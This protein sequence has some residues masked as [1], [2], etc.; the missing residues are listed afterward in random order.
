MSE[1]DPPLEDTLRRLAPLAD[2]LTKHPRQ[3]IEPGAEAAEK[4]AMAVLARVSL[5]TG[6]GLSLAHTLG[7]GGM[8]VV[9]LGTQ[10][11][12]GRDVAVKSLKP[13]AR[14]ARATL[15]LLREAW[16]TGALEHP[17]VVP[18]Y[19][20][21]LDE[22][23]GPRL[24]LKRIEGVE[25]GALIADARAVAA[26]FAGRSLLEWNLSIFLQVAQAV[27]FAH[28]RG[29]VHRDLK[30]ENVMIGAF[31][32]VYVLD[33][34]IAVALAD[35]G[36]GRLPLASEAHEMAGTPAYMAPEMLG[37]PAPNL[38]VHTD[39]YLLGGLLYEI[40]C[41]R[42]PHAGESLMELVNAIARSRPSFP[43]LAPAE[44]VSICQRA[45]HRDPAKR[46]ASAEAL[47]L[48]VQ[49][50]L[51][52]RG[53]LQ[54]AREATQG[55]EELREELTRPPDAI[56][57]DRLYNA[58]GAVRFGF[59]QALR[60]WPENEHARTGLREATLRL[61]EHELRAGDPRSASTL[62]TE[63]QSPPA[64]LVAQ[65][66]EARRRHDAE[67]ARL[68]RAAEDF[69]PEVGRRTRSFIALVLGVFWSGMP[70]IQEIEGIPVTTRSWVL[71]SVFFLV[72]LIGAGIWA[73]ETMMRTAFN[74]AMGSALIFV[75]V[76][77][78]A[79]AAGGTMMRLDID[80]LRVGFVFLW[81]ATASFVAITLERRI[82]PAAIGFLVAF[83]AAAKWPR[84]IPLCM[85]LSNV[86]LTV[87]LLAVWRPRERVLVELAQ[88][89]L[90]RL[91]TRLEQARA[92]RRAR[93]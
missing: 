44:L 29:I 66:A 91:Q 3:T 25:W 93:P 5:G 90:A 35:D 37:G 30:P 19:D 54:L 15:K 7:E 72:A 47:A 61:I 39:V 87:N 46:F 80:Q 76:A 6:G 89:R 23:G 28:S 24:V 74:R 8:G 56:D 41:G 1:E 58:Y 73:R 21:G 78:L 22:T 36:T 42:P 49:G 64:E 13:E 9:R 4:Q 16:I 82:A 20:L 51:Q 10:L 92:E 68:A 84:A 40:L 75:F 45:L 17:N 57:R 2:T 83:F 65:V 14:D 81:A 79:L 88:Q 59:Q 62:L 63:L 34:G 18:V 53:S 69:S 33:W 55:L 70:L 48:A 31:G 26:R 71:W 11:A 27:H 67:Q 38:G 32:E 85:S 86:V 50:Y 77:Q 43:D 60:A 12:L 52:H